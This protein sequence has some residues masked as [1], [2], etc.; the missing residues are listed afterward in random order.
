MIELKGK[1]ITKRA[2][3]MYLRRY[4]LPGAYDALEGV[5]IPYIE[6]HHRIKEMGEEIVKDFTGKNMYALAVLKGA[7]P[8]FTDLLFGENMTLPFEY[9]CVQIQSYNG[10]Q[11]GTLRMNNINLDTI[12]GKDV[13]IVEDILDT[14][15]TLT[16]LLHSLG[17]RPKSV[18]VAV[19]LD[20][21]SRRV[22]SVTA[23]Y[24][25]FTIADHFVVGYGMDYNGNFRY[26]QSIGVLKKE[27][28]SK[29]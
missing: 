7:I 15:K 16:H 24:V 11:S 20:K 13:L 22:N 1:D 23:D 17:D 3:D 12:V 8:F 6:L 5:L 26:L 14:G 19:L 10:Q 25:G 27:W 28:S 29:S 21:P 18:K 4:T 9:G 2:V